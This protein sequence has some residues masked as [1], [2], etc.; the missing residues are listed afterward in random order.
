MGRVQDLFNF[1]AA[2][3]NGPVYEPDYDQMRLAKQIRRVF[4]CMFDGQWRTLQEIALITGDQAP[5]ISAQ[6]RHLRKARHGA[7]TVDKR[8]RGVRETGLW[9]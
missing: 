4:D 9:E 7:H 1:D 3:F 2:E 8:P 6:L 5:S